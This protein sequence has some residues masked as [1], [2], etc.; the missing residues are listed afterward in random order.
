[1]DTKAF[2]IISNRP[3]QSFAIWFLGC[4]VPFTFIFRYED[5]YV[6]SIA[7]ALLITFLICTYFASVLTNG[8]V[9]MWLAFMIVIN[10]VMAI[11]YGYFYFAFFTAMFIGRIRNTVGFYV[12]YGIHLGITVGAILGGF[13]IETHLYI[14]QIPYMVLVVFGAILGPFYLYSRKQN[15]ELEGQL[16]TANERISELSVYEERQRIAR[17]LHD[18]LGQKLSMVGLKLDL[19]I[20]LVD[21]D[22]SKAKEELK[23][24]RKT[25]SMALKEVREM[26]SDMK[27]VKLSD[28]LLQVEKLLR[29]AGIDCILEGDRKL[30]E[31]PLILENTLSMCLKEAVNNVVRHSAAKECIIT[32]EQSTK[33]IVMTIEDDGKGLDTSLTRSNGNG[34]RGMKERIEFVNGRME[35]T[36]LPTGTRLTFTVPLVIVYQKG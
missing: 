8:L 10:A 16:Q 2:E 3:F 29:V 25:A 34:L 1:M 20:R 24:V 17:D 28:E 31:V 26:V 30:H 21:K 14:Q 11:L 13:F 6:L 9:Y 33:D 7:V 18:T 27:K 36:P 4:F 5:T 32:V 15:T 19:A 35:I 22:P 12:M 23:D